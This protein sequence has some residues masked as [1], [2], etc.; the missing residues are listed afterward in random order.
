MWGDVMK[1]KLEF[2]ETLEE[3]SITIKAR[4]Y[5]D[6]IKSIHQV[7]NNEIKKNNKVALYINQTEYF[8]EINKIVF[9][10]TEDNSIYAHT[11]DKVYLT[12]YTLKHLED[13]LPSNFLRISKST[14]I[15][16]DHI[17]SIEKNITSSSKV[18]FSN[19][20]KEVYVSRRYLKVLQHLIFERS[21]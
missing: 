7:I 16:V 11:N 6:N 5:D 4:V 13:V 3:D 8:I 19:C 2:D 10:E 17:Y 12:K 14:I 18:T 21:L 9:F 15:N 20:S 1:L